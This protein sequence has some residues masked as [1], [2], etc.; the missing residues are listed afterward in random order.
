M[1]QPIVVSVITASLVS[2]LVSALF[3]PRVIGG[4]CEALPRQLSSVALGDGLEQRTRTTEMLARSS[5]GPED[6][7]KTVGPAIDAAQRLKALGYF[8]DWTNYMLVTTVAA[9]G[10]VSAKPPGAVGTLP[11]LTGGTASLPNVAGVAGATAAVP[12][13][14]AYVVILCL[15]LSVVFA[16][17]T[18]PILPGIAERIVSGNQSFYK[19]EF[20][21]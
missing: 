14:W 2:A 20:L 8:K 7:G 19:I 11:A 9:I 13:F 10:W 5:Q 17:L 21:V 12:D 4:A 3:I 15:S 18:L 1:T 16:V 6:T